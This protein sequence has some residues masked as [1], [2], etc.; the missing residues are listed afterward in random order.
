[1]YVMYPSVLWSHNKRTHSSLWQLSKFR[2]IY[3][4]FFSFKGTMSWDPS[5]FPLFSHVILCPSFYLPSLSPSPFPF[6]NWLPWYQVVIVICIVLN[7]HE[8]YRVRVTYK[9]IFFPVLNAS[10]ALSITL[11]T[12]LLISPLLFCSFPLHQIGRHT[13]VNITNAVAIRR[14]PTSPMSRLMWRR[15]KH[16]GSTYSTMRGYVWNRSKVMV[17]SLVKV[18]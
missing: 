2:P 18:N 5:I 7:P 4:S 12:V 16:S 1:M 11:C 9:H 13:V 15:G 17:V 3:F 10:L 8:V 6:E 14:T